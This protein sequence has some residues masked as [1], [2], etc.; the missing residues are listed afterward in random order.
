MVNFWRMQFACASVPDADYAVFTTANDYV[1]AGAACDSPDGTPMRTG[2]FPEKRPIQR[3]QLERIVKTR[4][5]KG[6]IIR[7]ESSGREAG[8]MLPL[9]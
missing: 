1:T 6:A 7:T 8:W 5:K 4:Q 9:I 3:T 2:N